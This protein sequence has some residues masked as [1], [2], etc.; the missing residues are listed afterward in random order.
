MSERITY[1]DDKVT[2]KLV[3]AIKAGQVA[4]EEVVRWAERLENGEVK[5]LSRA[6]KSGVSSLRFAARRRISATIPEHPRK[7]TELLRSAVAPAKIVLEE[8]EV[9]EYAPNR[10]YTIIVQRD[11]FPDMEFRKVREK[12][13]LARYDALEA[14]FDYFFPRHKT[15]VASDDAA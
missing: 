9:E 6:L 5:G 10:F 14:A 4:D 7:M 3:E 2:S 13:K 8:G 11:G 12:R 15:D 1:R